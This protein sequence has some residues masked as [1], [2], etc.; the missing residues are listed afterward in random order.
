[1]GILVFVILIAATI[2]YVI[3]PF[4]INGNSIETRPRNMEVKRSNIGAEEDIEAQILKIRQ[5]R[6]GTCPKCGAKN[7]HDARFCRICATSL[8]KGKKN[9]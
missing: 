2:A 7:P 1:M 4:F 3:Y 5:S 8:T 9:D 6:T